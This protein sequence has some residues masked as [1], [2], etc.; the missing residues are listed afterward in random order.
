MSST[1]RTVER[2]WSPKVQSLLRGMYM[3]SRG[4]LAMGMGLDAIQNRVH[5]VETWTVR[6]TLQ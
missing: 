3:D 5:A 4:P 1:T 2:F 6:R